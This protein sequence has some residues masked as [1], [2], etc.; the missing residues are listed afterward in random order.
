MVLKKFFKSLIPPAF[1]WIYRKARKPV[2]N[3]DVLFDGEDTLFKR[4]LPETKCYAEYGC[5][6]STKWVLNNTLAHVVAVDTSPQWVADVLAENGENNSRLTIRHIDLGEVGDWGFPVGYGRE[7]FKDYTDWPWSQAKKPDVVLI[8][9][10]F[11]VCCFL[12][13][14]KNA[15]EG[16]KII[17][18]DYGNRP[19]YHFIEKYLDPVEACGRQYLDLEE[20]ERDIA[21]FRHVMD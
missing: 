2:V 19:A 21:D 8:D 5:G 6:A 18:D 7:Y 20:L 11:R 9:G 14:L 17:F 12:T 3:P 16:T 1:I 4:L 13:S 15:D 10:R